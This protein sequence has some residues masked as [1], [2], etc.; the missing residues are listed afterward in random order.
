MAA[1]T[2]YVVSGHSDGGDSM[3]N[4]EGIARTGGL[5]SPRAQLTDFEHHGTAKRMTGVPEPLLESGVSE[6][7]PESAT[8]E[9]A[10]ATSVED[11]SGWYSDR[12]EPAQPRIFSR[13]EWRPRDTAMKEPHS[14]VATDRI[15]RSRT[16][17]SA[18]VAARPATTI[19]EIATPMAAK[20]ATADPKGTRKL[21][22]EMDAD[23]QR[24]KDMAGEQTSSP[25]LATGDLT[26]GVDANPV[27]SRRRWP[28]GNFT[29]EQELTR[30]QI[31]WQSFAEEVVESAMAEVNAESAP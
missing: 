8:N 17:A 23:N 29:P 31:G 6:I 26:A 24:G 5:V 30:A 9:F 20:P 28:R 1:L 4:D 14:T 12:N 25:A 21:S 7:S 2:A 15:H 10:G 16:Q 19:P 22:A 27:G 3:A 11:A 13:G 18:R